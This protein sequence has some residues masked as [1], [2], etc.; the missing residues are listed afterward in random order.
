MPQVMRIEEKTHQTLRKLSEQL[1][2]PMQTI[3]SKAVEDFRRNQMFQEAHAA[4][5]ALRRDP[6]AWKEEL[7]E[8]QAWAGTLLDNLKELDDIPAR[9]ESKRATRRR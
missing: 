9:R 3:V 2:Q 5:A 7:D 1:K 8:R 6:K 4:F